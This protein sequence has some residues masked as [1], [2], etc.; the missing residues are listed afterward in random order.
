MTDYQVKLRGRLVVSGDD[1]EAAVAK[2]VLTPDQAQRLWLYL[3][4]ESRARPKFDGVHV[5]YYGGALL[6]IAAMGW[7]LTTAW[8]NAGGIGLTLMAVAYG[9]AFWM[10]GDSLWNRRL[11][12]PGGLL[13]TMAVCMTP[14]A[15]YGLERQLR[16]WPQGDPGSYHDYYVWIRGSWFLMEVAT[17]LVGAIAVWRRPFAFLTAP[18]AF[19]LWFMSMDLAPL[20]FGRDSLTWSDR[21]WVSVWFGLAVLLASY[22]A[23]LRNRVRQDFAFWGY[24]FGSLAFW[25]GLSIMEGSTE[26]SKFL[27]CVINL[28]MIVLSVLLRQ[29]VFVVFGALGVLGYLGHLSYR[30]FADSLL[31]PVV[32]VMIGIGI[33]YLAVL[34]QRNSARIAAAAQRS[35]PVAIQNLIPLRARM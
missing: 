27:Y 5:A 6:V 3:A 31:F 26:L 4:A 10:A 15:V 16:W 32:L 13:F 11:V 8:E 17:I 19:A 9:A 12:V 14:L 2:G 25:G 33:I 22:V 7:L 35:L 21:E 24:L 20:V 34:Y 23:D 30:V 1:L 29:R 28:F 18:I